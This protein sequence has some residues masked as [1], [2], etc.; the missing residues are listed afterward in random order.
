MEYSEYKKI[1]DDY[2]L[3]FA[4]Y[5]RIKKAILIKY[6]KYY[7]RLLVIGQENIPDGPAILAP[8]HP[9]G[10][11]L[12]IFALEY[13]GHK[14]REITT[15]VVE[16]WHFLNHAWG[17]WYVGGGIPLWMTGGLRYDYTDPYLKEG[18]EKYPGIICI[19]PEGNVPHFRDRN[20]VFKYFPGVVRLA[21]HYRAPIIP[22][23]LINFSE[24]CPVVK[25]I[26]KEKMPDDIICLPFAFPLKLRIEYG[27]PVYLDEYYGRRLS[28]AEEFWIANEI[29]KPAY[30]DLRQKYHRMDV[31]PVDVEMKKPD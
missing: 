16:S 14:T 28:K 19:Y 13:C 29:V 8:N 1:S 17:R 10:M 27:K 5:N 26:P 4:R 6:F 12:D 23:A 22:V 21:L 11:E 3:R 18:G 24:A 15:L 31:K 20:S 30:V 2:H 25:I 7:H 9:G